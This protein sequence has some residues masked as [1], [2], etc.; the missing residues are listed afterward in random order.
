MYLNLCKLLVH[1]ILECNNFQSIFHEL[2]N[3]YLSSKSI[4][5]YKRTPL[6][7]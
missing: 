6:H 3:I 5:S 2:K 4:S 1:K 7:D